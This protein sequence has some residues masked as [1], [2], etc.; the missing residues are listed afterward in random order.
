MLACF[1]QHQLCCCWGLHGFCMPLRIDFSLVAL[2]MFQTAFFV[3]VCLCACVLVSWWI[4]FSMVAV[5]MFKIE[6]FVLVCLCACVLVCLCVCVRVR[7]RER[8]RE[9]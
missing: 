9:R 4:E 8:E 2:S 3:L 6:F 7:E 5:S 1:Y